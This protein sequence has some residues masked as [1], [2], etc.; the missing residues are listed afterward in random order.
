MPPL[1]VPASRAIYATTWVSKTPFPWRI[2]KWVIISGGD[3]ELNKVLWAERPEFI[4]NGED[5]ELKKALQSE[6][7]HNHPSSLGMAKTRRATIK[8]PLLLICMIRDFLKQQSISRRFDTPVSENDQRNTHIATGQPSHSASFDYFN[9]P[10]SD[11]PSANDVSEPYSI[12][13]HPHQVH[14]NQSESHASGCSS[15][16]KWNDGHGPCN[17]TASKAEIV[18][19][20]SSHLPPP[21]RARMKCQWEECNL[22]D[23]ICRDTIL[24][25]IRQ[26]HLGINRRRQSSIKARQPKLHQRPQPY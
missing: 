23:L 15:V 18:N 22:P 12:K 16:C 26:I 14:A 19:H 7:I 13:S 3:S 2:A 24:R 8:C 9:P 17:E 21:G 6:F 1:V 25:H 20:L 11:D 10:F 4:D 5:S